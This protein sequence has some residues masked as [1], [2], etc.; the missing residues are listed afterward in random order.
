MGALGDVANQLEAAGK[1]RFPIDVAQLLGPVASTGELR[2]T[3]PEGWVAELPPTVKVDGPWGSYLSE[4]QQV[5]RELTIRRV[6]VGRRG[7]MAPDTV[8][9]L[10]QWLR[11]AAK[12]DTQFLV[13]SR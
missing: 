7:Y 6:V 8:G 3:M 12:D 10:I 1:R 11:D 4:Y 2:L 9:D 5:G 13:I